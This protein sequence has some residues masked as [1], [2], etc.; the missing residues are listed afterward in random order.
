MP[1]IAATERSDRFTPFI[2]QLA[3]TGSTEQL[4]AAAAY[5]SGQEIALLVRRLEETHC[6]TLSTET[7]AGIH[8]Q[9]RLII[10]PIVQQALAQEAAI[11][12]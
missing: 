1:T 9:A 7:I 11:H 8:R 10:E 5:I 3:S 4:A 2:R 12:A 6:L